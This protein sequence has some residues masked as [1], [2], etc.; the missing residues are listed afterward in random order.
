M[1]VWIVEGVHHVVPG[2]IVKVCATEELAELEAVDLINIIRKDADLPEDTTADD[3]PIKLEE[4]QEVLNDVRGHDD[5][6]V[7]PNV[8]ISEHEVIE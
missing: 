5:E 3:W 1:K 7:T 2:R 6:Y 4:A 8:D